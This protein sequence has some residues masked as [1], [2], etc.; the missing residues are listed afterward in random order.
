M[1]TTQESR[2]TG[3]VPNLDAWEPSLVQARQVCS[4]YVA[5]MEQGRQPYWLTLTGA[6]G[7]GKT[8]LLQQLF[9]QAQR[10]NPGNPANNPI[11]P[12][13]WETRPRGAVS[14]YEDSRPLCRWFTESGMAAKMREGFWELPRLLQEDW[15]VALDELGGARDPTNFVADA[16]AQVCDLRLG[17]WTLFAT[18]LTLGEISQ[19]VDARIASRLI[20]DDNRV[21]T[22]TAGDYALRTR[23]RELWA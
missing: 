2:T 23:P 18:N 12:P 5:D 21:L 8:R 14:V 1:Q 11:W 13:D 9:R 7:C 19:Q 17:R 3:W 22:I 16:V 4:R 15:C 20:R 6:N 10:L